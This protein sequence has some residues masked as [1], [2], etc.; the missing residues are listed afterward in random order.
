[1]FSSRELNA[2][3]MTT[4][5]RD[6]DLLITSRYHACILSLAAAVPQIAVGHDLRLKTLYA[7]LGLQANFIA[8]GPELF[9]RVR[10]GVQ[11]LVTG[12]EPVREFSHAL[13]HAYPEPYDRTGEDQKADRRHEKSGELP[14]AA[15]QTSHPR[16]SRIESDGEN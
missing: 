16:E 1:M 12:A 5:F 6:L 3:Q 2:S 8:P 13:D 9:E 7:E 11:Q 10:S 15:Q 4:L 14:P